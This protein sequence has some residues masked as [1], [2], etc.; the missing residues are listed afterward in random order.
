MNGFS[1]KYGEKHELGPNPKRRLKYGYFLPA[2]L[3]ESA[4]EGLVGEETR[5]LDVGGGKS[6]FPDNVPLANELSAVCRLLVAVDPSENI[7][8]NPFADQ[9]YQTLLED[10]STDQ[11][12]ELITMRMVVEH[13]EDPDKFM[14]KVSSLLAPGG[15]CVLFTVWKYAPVSLISALVPFRL[16]NSIKRVFWG[17]EEEDT[18]PTHYK[19]NTRGAQ[20]QYASQAGLK[21][22]VMLR[23]ND[24]SVTGAFGSLANPE[25]LLESGFR[26]LGLPYPE[27]C[28]LSAFRK[29]LPSQ[30]KEH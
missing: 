18:F 16:H 17:T 12:F 8:Q 27:H 30:S 7:L 26:M 21:S 20:E 28:L 22:V 24:C 29:P 5:W 6:L 4:V 3:Y 9:K 23:L 19:L 14:W 15:I 1:R 10:W 25:L 13:V 11:T 2:D